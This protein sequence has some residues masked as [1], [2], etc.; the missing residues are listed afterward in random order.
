MQKLPTLPIGTVLQHRYRL[1]KKLASGGFGAVYLAEDQRLHCLVAVKELI[2]PSPVTQALFRQEA[3]VLAQIDHPG[4]VKVSDFFG[5]GRSHY[6]VMDYIAGKDLLELAVEAHDAGRQLPLD[7]VVRWM[8]QV[9]KAVAYL[10]ELEPPIIHRDIKPANIRLDA[11]QRA[12]LV[13]FGIAKVDPRT[14]TQSMA[15]AISR[16]FSP[17]EQ[18]DSAG[19]TDT[20]SDIYALGATF[21]CLLTVTPPP[22]SFKRLTQ[23][24]SFIL[25]SRINSQVSK[26]LDTVVLKAMA[27]NRLQRYQNGTE[28]LLALQSAVGRPVV[29]PPKP[30]D[31]VAKS[32][33]ATTPS[34][35]RIVC[36][37]CGMVCRANARF[38]PR[39]GSE[40]QTSR[41]CVHCGA[42]NRPT[43]RFCARCSA[44]LS[45]GS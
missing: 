21:Y 34:S 1:L 2:R 23:D 25:P 29:R 45:D 13:D 27:L 20:R 38:C 12:I 37:H 8:L 40:L 24:Y 32:G 33:R 43:A 5:E 39:C 15:H 35:S 36:S 42:L 11:H 28:M 30:Q 6:L 9:C 18:Y 26:V 31:I 22:D 17:P 16:G 10:H 44:K 4:L 7:Q 14:T 41:V 3:A 19:R